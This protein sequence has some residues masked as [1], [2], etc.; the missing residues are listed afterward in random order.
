MPLAKINKC[1]GLREEGGPFSGNPA[2]LVRLFGSL[3]ILQ[4]RTRGFPA[5]DYSGCG[6]IGRLYPIVHLTMPDEDFP[7]KDPDDGVGSHSGRV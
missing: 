6:L 4:P 5:P 7:V 2:I 3:A 1:A